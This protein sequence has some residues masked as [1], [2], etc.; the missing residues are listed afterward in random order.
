MGAS[1][2]SCATIV[3]AAL[4]SFGCLLTIGCST[5]TNKRGDD[6]SKAAVVRTAADGLVSMRV[7]LSTDSVEVGQTAALSA[8]IKAPRGVTVKWDDYRSVLLEDDRR[9]ELTIQSSSKE[10]SVP[11]GAD[12]LA[13]RYHYDLTFLLPGAIELPPVSIQYVDL[14]DVTAVANAATQVPNEAA[15]QQST[16]DAV[17][18]RT[19]KTEP[20]TINVIDAS[21]G[22]LTEADLHDIKVLD[23]VELRRPWSHWAW[24]APLGL[25]AIAALLVLIVRRRRR[26]V[27]EQAIRIP[28]HEWAWHQIARLV[29]D[30]LMSKGRV[31]EFYY[32]VSDIVRGYVERRFSVSAPEMTTEEFL[33]ATATDP[34]FSVEH[35]D[36][37]GRFLEACDLVKY[38]KHVPRTTEAD[39]L[40]A[41]ARMFIER[42]R[43]HAMPD[44]RSILA[45]AESKERAA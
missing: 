12:Q 32:R 4:V 30:D 8:E 28:A 35:R 39:E 33:H 26:I 10:E 38:A 3:R 13:W 29:A 36:G 19:L 22:A 23:P 1:L 2:N 42:T 34:R 25:V 24:I 14:R 5:E 20:I 18:P 37:V 45:Q 43:E 44:D 16:G 17:E 9:F 27:E 31:Q 11:V 41:S 6:S 40:L 15:P 21:A 7:T